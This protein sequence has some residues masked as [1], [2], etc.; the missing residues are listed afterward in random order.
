MPFWVQISSGS[1][2]PIYTQVVTQ[3]SRGIA[4][5]LISPGDKLP[6]VRNLAS[7]LVI[8][9]NT[10]A[11]AYTILE[12]QGLVTTKTGS[13]TYVSDPRLREKDISQLNILNERIDNIVAHALNLGLDH[14]DILDL[15]RRRLSGF[16]SEP[17]KEKGRDIDE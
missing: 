6:A 4:Q 7:E 16:S 13:G 8:N 1:N 14:N 15:L 12:Q 11:R 9:P 17:G 2:E 10:V 5:G 3:I